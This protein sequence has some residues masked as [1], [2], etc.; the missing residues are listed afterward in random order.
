MIHF[1]VSNVETY[2]WLPPL[3]AFC[4]SSLT[5]TGGV[6]GAFLLLPFQVSVLE[7]TEPAVSSTNLM[8][9]VVANPSGV[10]RYWRE[11]RM[12]WPLA[13]ATLLGTLPGLFFGAII[14]VVYLPDP[15]V[16]KPFAGCVLGYVGYRLVKDIVSQPRQAGQPND[17][18]SGFRVTSPKIN[19]R[20]LSYEFGGRSYRASTWGIFALSLVVGLVGGAYGIGGGAIIAP[21]LVTVFGLPVYTVAG[22][23][24]LGTFVSSIAGIFIYILIGRLYLSASA[25]TSPDWAL[26]ALFGVGGMFGVYVGARLQ[27]YVPARLINGFLAACVLF[28]AITYISELIR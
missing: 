2:W 23:A 1:P 8:Y 15:R 10:Y 28:I 19:A 18:A 22:A 21:F 13:G 12:V 6:S 27:R 9:N 17:M 26:G 4:I 3:V 11:K 5:A 16:F 20:F 24:L 25:A 7:F 14:R